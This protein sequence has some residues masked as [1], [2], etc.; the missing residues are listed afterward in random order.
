MGDDA[1]AGKDR[2]SCPGKIFGAGGG[3]YSGQFKNRVGPTGQ[4]PP[5]PY[6]LVKNGRLAPLG[7]IP[8][9]LCVFRIR[10]GVT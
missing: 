10:S 5:G 1:G 7:C 9:I 3:S 4:S 2:D 8:L 6:K